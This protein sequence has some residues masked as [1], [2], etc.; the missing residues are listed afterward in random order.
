MRRR[1]QES[2]NYCRSIDTLFTLIQKWLKV[3][4]DVA[5]DTVQSATLESFIKDSTP[6]KH[7]VHAI[8]CIGRF[9]QNI[10]VGK[11]LED[12]FSALRVCV[13]DIRN[14]PVLQQW[15]DDYLAFAKSTLK[16]VDDNDPE[17]RD[18]RQA[19]RRRWKEL[20]ESDSDKRRQ[21]TE[22]FAALRQEVRG[23]Q[24]RIGKDKDLR[25][26]RDAH[27]QFGRDLDDA[28]IDATAVGLQAAISGTSW[29]WTDLFSVYLPRLVCMLKS[30]P[31]P[32]YVYYLPDVFSSLKCIVG[33]NTLTIRLSLC[34]K[35][36]ISFLLGFFRDTFSSVTSLTLK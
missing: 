4:G 30:I 22:D 35:I 25:A 14:D 7:L 2:P 5:V 13:I 24:E 23:F 28:L 11:S 17:I 12:L 1:A 20:T 32:R 16:Q 27:A 21:W 10:A 15:V 9:A 33:P 26:V 6:E 36:S 31:I 34:L 18:T 3:T 19:L 8:R 29:L